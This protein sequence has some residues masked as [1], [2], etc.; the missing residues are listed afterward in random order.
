MS[1]YSASA[2]ALAAH[3]IT[4]SSSAHCGDFEE[5]FS[6]TIPGLVCRMLACKRTNEGIRSSLFRLPPQQNPDNHLTHP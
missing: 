6:Q 4:L 5:W 1:Q 2:G 3:R